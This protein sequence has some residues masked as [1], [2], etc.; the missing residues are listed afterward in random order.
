MD[1]NIRAGVEFLRILGID[2]VKTTKDPI[3][4]ERDDAWEELLTDI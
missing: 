2:G 4:E 1:L 3:F